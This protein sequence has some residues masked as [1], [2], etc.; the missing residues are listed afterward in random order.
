[1]DVA[2]KECKRQMY[3]WSYTMV[4]EL[5]AGV[6]WK[7]KERQIYSNECSCGT[8]LAVIYNGKA[9]YE[10]HWLLLTSLKSHAH[11]E[12]HPPGHNDSQTKQTN[13][14][15]GEATGL[16]IKSKSSVSF[17]F[18]SMNCIL[19]VI[20]TKRREERLVQVDVDGCQRKLVS[21][22]PPP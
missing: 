11:R 8:W 13:K 15:T 18:H 1:M 20:Y 21:I 22:S 9:E 6:E 4:A 17:R 12:E 16:S 5:W 10:V 2:G 19:I 3:H 14:Q 7:E